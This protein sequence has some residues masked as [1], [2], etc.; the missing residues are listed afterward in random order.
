MRI[1][2]AFS[3]NCYRVSVS[4]RGG[5]EFCVSRGRAFAPHADLIWMETK[6]PGLALARQF[7]DGVRQQHPHQ[8]FAYNLSP[9]FNWDAAGLTREQLAT[10]QVPITTTTTTTTKQKT[11]TLFLFLCYFILK[12]YQQTQ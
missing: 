10:F 7:A 2:L 6:T 5:I 4:V 9:S 1:F 11:Q 12:K 3:S 8:L